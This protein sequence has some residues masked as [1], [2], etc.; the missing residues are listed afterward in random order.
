MNARLVK[1]M[2][3]FFVECFN[4][5]KPAYNYFPGKESF[6]SALLNVHY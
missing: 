6:L 3:K 5:I 4:T 1:V 2:F